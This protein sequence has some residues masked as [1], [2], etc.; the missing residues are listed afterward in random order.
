MPL[1]QTAAN[2]VFSAETPQLEDPEGFFGALAKAAEWFI[3]L[4]QAGGEVFVGLVTGIIPLLV[5]LLTAVN[6]L[7][8]LIGPDK[9]DKLGELAA[10]PGIV[11]YPVRYLVLPVLSVFFLTNPMAYT[12]GS[13][14]EEK[15]KPAFYDAAVSYVHPPLGLFPHVNPGE[16]FVW[17]GVLV[18][19]LELERQG[20][21]ASG[22][23][24]QVAIWYAIVGLIVILLKGMLTERITA[25][26]A[27][28]QGV[29]L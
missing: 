4:F 1:L 6:A 14:L 15:H 16:Y 28:R 21:V 23:H 10:R 27:R 24:I 11:W 13:F 2:L 17:G 9:I 22:Y 5:V 12:F 25:I 18:A 20:A 29:E 7:I 8:R 26:M 19:L 3:G